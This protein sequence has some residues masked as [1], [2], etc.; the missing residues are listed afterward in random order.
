MAIFYMPF[1]IAFIISIMIEPLIKLFAKKTKIQRK[2]S[3]IIVLILVF[4]VIVRTISVGNCII[5]IRRCKSYKN[6][7]PICRDRI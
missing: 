3:A 1:L 4:G 7:R 2:P 6:V 5:N